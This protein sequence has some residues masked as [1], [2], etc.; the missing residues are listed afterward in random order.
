MIRGL[1]LLCEGDNAQKALENLGKAKVTISNQ[2]LKSSQFVRL[3]NY[4]SIVSV[5]SVSENKADLTVEEVSQMTGLSTDYVRN[6]LYPISL[7]ALTERQIE[8]SSEGR[9]K[10]AGNGPVDHSVPMCS[11]QHKTRHFVPEI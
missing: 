6:A 5:I 4:E 1:C 11:L 3:A 8:E 2:G 9:G 10:Y 7:Y